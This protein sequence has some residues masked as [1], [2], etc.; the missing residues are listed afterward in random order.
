MLA[1]TCSTP[2]GSGG[3]GGVGPQALRVYTRPSTRRGG[4]VMPS[5]CRRACRGCSQR[6]S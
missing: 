2:G 3:L 5:S 6:R 4:S 1:Q